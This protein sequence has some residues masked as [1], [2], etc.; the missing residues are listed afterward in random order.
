MNCTRAGKLSLVAAT[1]AMGF[2]CGCRKEVIEPE[3]QSEAR[4]IPPVSEPIPEQV[5]PSLHWFKT[6][7]EATRYAKSNKSEIGVLLNADW[8]APCQLLRRE[9]FADK[10]VVELLKPI[11]LVTIQFDSNEG[12]NLAKKYQSSAVPCLLILSPEGKHLGRINGYTD[13]TDF[14]KKLAR[15]L[16]H[17]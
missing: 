8:S 17:G 9:A 14:Q 16:N 1:V 11:A 13:V 6:L 5:Q 7:D 15:A 2:V 3:A 4:L 12:K 10:K